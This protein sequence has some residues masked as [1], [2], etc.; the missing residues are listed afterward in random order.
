MLVA[1]IQRFCIHDGPGIR[2]TVFM[3][4]C[5]L[6][7]IWCHN[8]ETQNPNPQI[9]FYAK[10]CIG[11]GEC[12]VT[13]KNCPTGA[14]ELC[15]TEYSTEEL[16][17][18]IAKD[19]MFYGDKGGVTFSGGEPFFQENTLKE[20]LQECKRNGIN[21]AIETCGYFNEDVLR[22]LAPYIDLLL[23]DIKDTNNIRHKKYTGVS[24]EEILKNLS[25]ADSLDIKIRLRCVLIN[26][27]NTNAEHYRKVAEIASGLRCCEEVEYLPYH[28]CGEA[29]AK[30]CG[31]PIVADKAWIPT[32]EQIS[33]AKQYLGT[34]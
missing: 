5:P 21:T 10:K 24:N 14:K 16:L 32:K 29:K 20:V 33:V 1:N 4:G 27:I 9:L 18:E 2:T 6:H 8:P 34:L 11:C 3:K 19:R 25:I 12:E 23:W 22:K 28:P 26:G 7:C 13:Y 17:L 30:A 31:I 15:G